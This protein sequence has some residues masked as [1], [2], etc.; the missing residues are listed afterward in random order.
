[1]NE[2]LDSLMDRICKNCGL[3]YGSHRT[4]SQCPDH[5]GRMDWSTE[6]VTIFED[7]GEVKKI[8]FGTERKR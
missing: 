1:M 2:E 3:T 4:D 8:P 7:S 6:Y 5:A